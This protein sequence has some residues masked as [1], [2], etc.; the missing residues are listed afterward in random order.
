MNKNPILM[1]N[2]TNNY[3]AKIVLSPVFSIWT[4]TFVFNFFFFDSL[5]AYLSNLI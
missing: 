4:L 2:M 1:A 5:I 3:A